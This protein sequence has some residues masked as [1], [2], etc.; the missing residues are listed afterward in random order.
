MNEY[1]ATK[2]WSIFVKLSCSCWFSLIS[3]QLHLKSHYFSL[4]LCEGWL[5]LF[6]IRGSKVK[7][8]FTKWQS[9]PQNCSV[10]RNNHPFLANWTDWALSSH[11]SLLL[12]DIFPDHLSLGSAAPFG[13]PSAS[14]ENSFMLSLCLTIPADVQ[15]TTLEGVLS[16]CW[17]SLTRTLT[18]SI[19]IWH[20]AGATKSWSSVVSLSCCW[21]VWV[22]CLRLTKNSVCFSAIS[23]Q[24]LTV[25]VDCWFKIEELLHK[26]TIL[27][28]D[29]ES[30]TAKSF[31][32]C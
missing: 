3:Y 13:R 16:L 26:M 25:L 15:D 31:F 29:L 1:G 28:S 21:F 4:F 11:C 30:L 27:V 22:I 12:L 7:N 17:C 24:P 32:P 14:F 23:V 18:T 10:V 9:P 2:C 19:D 20:N 5:R 8:F 6:L